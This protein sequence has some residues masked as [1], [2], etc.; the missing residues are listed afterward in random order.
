MCLLKSST[1]RNIGSEDSGGKNGVMVLEDFFFHMCL[2]EKPPTLWAWLALDISTLNVT[3]A[4]PVHHDDGPP[5]TGTQLQSLCLL[6][7]LF[8]STSMVAASMKWTR[9]T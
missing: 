6:C 7:R 4:M 5:C 8:Q 9:I 3:Q 1:I 2:Y